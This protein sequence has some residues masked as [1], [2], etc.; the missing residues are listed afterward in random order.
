M[1]SK[2]VGLLKQFFVVTVED[3]YKKDFIHEINSINTLRVKIC[4][5]T[6]IV[7]EIVVI[8]LTVLIKR[9]GMFDQP[10]IYYLYMYFLLTAG[11]IF[12]LLS[13]TRLGKDVQ[14][15]LKKIQIGGVLFASYILFWC[16]GI[17]LLDQLSYGQIV[18][19]LSAIICVGVIPFFPPIVLFFI[20]AASEAFFLI[21]QPFFQESADVVF[22]NTVNTLTFVIFSLVISRMRYKGFV[23]DFQNKRIIEEKNTLLEER[24]LLLKEINDQLI[25]ANLKLEKLSQRD[26]LTGVYN[27]MVFD[28]TLK[29]EW[30]RCKRHQIPLTLMMVDI[31]FFKQYNDT[32]GHQA[33]DECIK[34]V[35]EVLSSCARRSSDIITR[36]GGDEFALILPHMDRERALL[37]AEEMS[38]MVSELRIPHAGSLVSDYITISIGANTLIPS[39]DS[40]IEDLLKNADKALYESKMVRNRIVII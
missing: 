8:L 24:S 36:Y 7:C 4:S 22:G 16:A 3:K 35:A 21:L 5:I 28:R 29:M 31:D 23:E 9:K 18:V 39:K 11:M 37:L 1:L 38:R 33:G 14:R 15:N 27:R 20:F 19:Y 17:S 32:Y 30:D 10:D 6:F 34:R 2:L 26:S 25:E 40:R 12:F 13:F